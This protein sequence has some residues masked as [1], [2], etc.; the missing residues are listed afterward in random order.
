MPQEVSKSPKSSKWC[1]LGRWGLHWTRVAASQPTFL[2]ARYIPRFHA[3]NE[4]CFPAVWQGINVYFIFN[5]CSPPTYDSIC[6]FPV[7]VTAYVN[8]HVNQ[9]IWHCRTTTATSV[10]GSWPQSSGV[11]AVILP[12]RRCLPWWLWLMS[13]TMVK[14]ICLNSSYWC[15]TI[16]ATQTLWTK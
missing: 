1:Q 4:G 6:N 12:S 2:R 13:I 9:V 16:W 14:L 7:A 8:Q 10:P 5:I 11:M 3:R 15:T